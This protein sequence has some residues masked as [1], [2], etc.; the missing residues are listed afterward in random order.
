MAC[1]GQRMQGVPL[2]FARGRCGQPDAQL[3]YFLME[4]LLGQTLKGLIR[5]Y[6]QDNELFPVSRLLRL[7]MVLSGIVERL[8]RIGIVHR[9]IKPENI[10]L[11]AG[12]PVLID[13]GSAA[14]PVTL[15]ARPNRSERALHGTFSTMAPEQARHERPHVTMD[16]F[17]LGAT[18]RIALFGNSP[19]VKADEVFLGMERD[20]KN[21]ML[22]RR[23][24]AGE[25]QPLPARADVSEA[26]REVLEKAM[27]P[28][29]ARRYTSARA[30]ARAL[31]QLLR[32]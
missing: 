25:I 15:T 24:G 7:M 1:T 4:E 30:F 20:Y 13:F 2:I 5:E 8:H 9:D 18:M 19:Y 23:A 26:L 17:S 10:F 32:S 29:P 28:D 31:R 12:A 14:A 11:Q 3:F 22:S 21:E 16:V 27:A 6:D